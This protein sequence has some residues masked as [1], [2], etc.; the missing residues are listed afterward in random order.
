MNNDHAGIKDGD[1]TIAPDAI[2]RKEQP[3]DPGEAVLL[4]KEKYGEDS[5]NPNRDDQFDEHHGTP[6]D[7]V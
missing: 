3:I 6:D 7:I 5:I 1:E 2:P 4:E